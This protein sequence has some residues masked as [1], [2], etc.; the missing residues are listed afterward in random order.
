[1]Q[2]VDVVQ[3]KIKHQFK[4]KYNFVEALVVSVIGSLLKNQLDLP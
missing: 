1:M 4:E 3:L 2:V